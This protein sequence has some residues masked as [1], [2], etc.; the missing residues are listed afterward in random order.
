MMVSTGNVL[1]MRP[2]VTGDYQAL[3]LGAT[4]LAFDFAG[5]GLSDGEYVSLGAYERD[6]LQVDETIIYIAKIKIQNY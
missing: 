3:S 2:R 5:S 4:F 1:A 6:D